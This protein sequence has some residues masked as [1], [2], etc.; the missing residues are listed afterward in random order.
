MRVVAAALLVLSLLACTRMGNDAAPAP[1][2]GFEEPGLFEVELESGDYLRRFLVYIPESFDPAAEV[3]AL[4]VENPTFGRTAAL[5]PDGTRLALAD[6]NKNVLVVNPATGDT[7]AGPVGLSTWANN[8]AWL[9]SG[10]LV[11]AGSDAVV[12]LSPDLE[13]KATHTEVPDGRE[14]PSDIFISGMCAA[15]GESV[16]LADSN[17]SRITKLSADGSAQL[18]TE[19]R[20][21]NDIFPTED[22]SKFVVRHDR[23]NITVFNA[24]D[25]STIGSFQVP[26]RTGVRYLNQQEH[27]YTAWETMPRLSPNGEYL[28]SPDRSGQLWALSM[29][30]GKPY[31]AFSR[32]TLGYAEDTLWL[33]DERFAVITNDGQVHIMGLRSLLPDFSERDVS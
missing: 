5:S 6:G 12:F 22:G 26:G 2:G 11:A 24:S 14:K 8:L 3:S 32:E 16:Y 33:D 15:G 10:D 21:P 25:F 19:V 1:A 30:K 9:D 27:S 18:V 13:V 20:Y 31:R 28:L 4:F 7:I 17:G 29:P 23:G